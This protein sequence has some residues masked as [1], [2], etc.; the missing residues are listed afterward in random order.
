MF[1]PAF[2]FFMASSKAFAFV[3]PLGLSFYNLES[4]QELPDN[5][6]WDWPSKTGCFWDFF[7][8]FSSPCMCLTGT[9]PKENKNKKKG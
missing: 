9:D 6:G 5:T 2:C 3:I 7:F 1:P 8:N 4:F